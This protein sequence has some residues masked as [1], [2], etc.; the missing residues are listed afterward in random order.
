MSGSGAGVVVVGAG[1]GGIRVAESLRNHGFT[2]PITLVGAEDHPPYDRPPLSKSVLLGKDDRV[3]LKPEEFYGESGITLRLGSAV[4]SVSPAGKTI[5]LASGDTLAYDTLVLATGLNP[6]PFPGLADAVAGV[7]MIRTYDDAVALRGEIDAAST[8]VVIG[9]G[10]IG[11]E[12]A[13]SLTS[14]GLSVSLVEPAPTPLAVAL[15]EEIGTL[16]SRLHTAN[17]VDLRT[18][19]GVAEIVVVEDPTGPK[20]TAVKLDDGT[21]LS[22]DIVVV[23]IGSTPVTGYLDGSGIELAPREAG[24]GIACD[25][26]GHTSAENVY[27]VGDVANWRDQDGT[28]HRVEHWN[29]TVEQASVV[30]HQ[31]AG[32]DAVTAGVSYFWS[33]QFDL[34]IQV[35]GSPRADDTVH[36]VDDDGK[37]FVA[38]YSRDGVLTGVV[39]AGKVGAVM[40]TRSKLQT[41][42]PIAD[43]L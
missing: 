34:K 21:E 42:T 28:P 13:A 22:A 16:V 15:G 18:G 12:V 5:T 17:G 26:T 14:R 8:A 27:A 1:L 31:I 37:K 41:P 9:A 30:A 19:V 25:A 3:D 39:G 43:L 29:H 32:G 35:L 6:R 40:K 20:V 24:G 11:C 4:T 10:F 33:D 38:Y 2:D 23:G 7:H 36:V